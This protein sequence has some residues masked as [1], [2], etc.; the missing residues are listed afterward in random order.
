MIVDASRTPMI[1]YVTHKNFA[2]KVNSRTFF[3]A[4]YQAWYVGPI[5]EYAAP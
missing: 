4:T 3:D 2:K 1:L 5:S